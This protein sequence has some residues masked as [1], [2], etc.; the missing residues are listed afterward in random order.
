MP[1]RY[2]HRFEPGDVVWGPDAFHDD[3]PHLQRQATRPWLVVSNDAFPGQG[4]QYIVCGLTHNLGRSPGMLPLEPGDW[5][6]GGTPR[7]SQVDTE[8][9]LTMKQEWIT[10]YSGRL[11]HARLQQ[12][13]K[14]IRGYL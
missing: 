14:A 13:R 10:D 8:T 1:A 11:S 3:D 7:K 6:T 2:R 12:A 9:L 4:R 5:T